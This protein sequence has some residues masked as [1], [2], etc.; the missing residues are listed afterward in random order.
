MHLH[1]EFGEKRVGGKSVC[2]K[3][4]TE[5]QLIVAAAW[6]APDCAGAEIEVG[7]EV[8]GHWCPHCEQL[9]SLAFNS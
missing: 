6:S 5:T 1:F 8:S 9:T 7:E 3:C 2:L 4:G